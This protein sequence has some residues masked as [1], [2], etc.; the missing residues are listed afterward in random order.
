VGLVSASH[1]ARSTVRQLI[2]L[3]VSK[4]VLSPGSRNAPLSIALHEAY[5]KN[6]IDL[7]VKI[8]ERG[9]AFFALGISKAT[10]NYVAVICTSGTAVANYHPAALEAYHSQSNLI[11]LTA[12]RP[13]RLRKTGANQTTLQ[14]GILAPLKTTDTA[15]Q[16]DCSLLLNGG[17]VHI[18]LQFD[19]PLL[20]K[21]SNADW[22]AGISNR[23]VSEI[24]DTSG[25]LQV[26]PRSIIIIG[27]DCAGFSKELINKVVTASG[28]PYI[29][30]DPLSFSGATPHAAIFLSDAHIRESLKADE[31]VVIGRTTL[32]RSINTFIAQSSRTIVIDPRVKE[33]DTGR[34]ASQLL[35]KLP[36]IH[37]TS[38]DSQWNDSWENAGNLAEKS[39]ELN[40]SEQ[41]VAREIARQI[42][43][44]SALFVG[45]SRPVRDLE[46]LAQPRQGLGIHTFANRGL[47]GIDGNISTAFGIAT[48][49]RRTYSII[50][51]LTFLHDLSAL[52][53]ASS[54]N[55]TIFI[56]DNNGGG[57]FSTLPQ[58]GADGFE[59]IF[60]T[61]HNLNLESIIKGFG[62]LV[63]KV[64]TASDLARMFN[65]PGLHFVIIEV[66][67]REE[68]AKNLKDLHQRVVSAV[69]IGS[70]LA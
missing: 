39:L 34:E 36:A 59:Q 70:N 5:K 62:Y 8:D 53:N 4:F 22:L 65:H 48:T 40:W 26:S 52:T 7:H 69:R 32:S 45:S 41:F 17:P 20:E 27:H 50:G 28:L 12:D 58:A 25:E 64:K 61:P 38:L 16:I 57:I 29:A 67:S 56:I 51:D 37:P 1:L 30:E 35:F 19:E 44:G 31:I 21:D 47:A 33:I 68:N 13:A 46:A 66:P 10:N 55:H 42:P 18:N 15:D 11:F 54:D 2:E 3:G 24:I 43:D 60:G 23:K 63:E 6:L 49:M 14:N 9:A